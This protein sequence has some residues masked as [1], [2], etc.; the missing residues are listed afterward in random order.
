MKILRGIGEEE[1]FGWVELIMGFL[2]V[3]EIL[4][5]F[6]TYNGGVGNKGGVSVQG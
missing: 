6:L 2:N 4:W 1:G 3:S 5:Q